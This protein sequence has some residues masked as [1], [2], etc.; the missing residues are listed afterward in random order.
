MTKAIIPL[1]VEPLTGH[2]IGLTSHNSK[3][4]FLIFIDKTILQY[5]YTLSLD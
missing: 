3:K 4:V 2:R 1:K 5:N